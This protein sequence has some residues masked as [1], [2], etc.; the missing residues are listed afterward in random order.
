MIP[1]SCDLDLFKPCREKR[2]VSPKIGSEDFVAVFCGAHGRAN[3]LDS[4]LDAAAYL[5]KHACDGIKVLLVG[6]GHLKP[7][8][9]NRVK[10]EALSNVVFMDPLPK[11]QLAELI[12]RC[13]CGLMSLADI[14]AFQFG[15]SPNK[16]FDY[17]SCGLPV[18]CNYPGWL[19]GLIADWDCGLVSDAGN[20]ASLANALEKL[21]EDPI[22]C[23]TMGRNSRKLA[24][25]EFNRDN[26]FTRLEK[27]ILQFQ[28]T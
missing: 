10:N 1:N 17:I 22:R 15:T 14:E 25:N 19:A 20:A 13:D 3:G 27:L 16:F 7:H 9:M 6:D 4:V 2:I 11:N 5:K 24:E 21:A 12:S 26:L 23:A 28:K 18:V 8:L